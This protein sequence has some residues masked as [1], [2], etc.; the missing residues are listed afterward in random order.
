MYNWKGD[1]PSFI[2]EV[3]YGEM[4]SGGTKLQT[5]T[6]FDPATGRY[7]T[8]ILTP[9]GGEGQ[10]GAGEQQGQQGTL[11]GT[12][13]EGQPGGKPPVGT[14]SQSFRPD[15]SSL[16]G[17][18]STEMNQAAAKGYAEEQGRTYSKK[19]DAIQQ[20]G[21]DAQ[22]ELPQLKALSDVIRNPEFY[23]GAAAGHIEGASSLMRSMGLSSGETAGLMQ[24]AEKLGSSSSLAN[25]REMGASGA[26]RVPEMHMIEKMNYDRENIPE[27][28][29]AVVDVRTKLQQRNAE[30]SQ[31]AS[32][33]ASMNGGRIDSGFDRWVRDT[34]A[35]KPLLT[36]SEMKSYQELMKGKSPQQPV[37]GQNSGSLLPKGGGQPAVPSSGGRPQVNDPFG[38]RGG[39]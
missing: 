31:M 30:I 32:N 34:Y 10:P 22:S 28:N 9:G 4:T 14:G 25:V 13:W 11:S 19:F 17:I 38:L 2:P 39:G 15:Y 1:A 16:G 12:G 37:P 5:A 23:S 33:Y 6:R 18:A 21:L 27:A 3:R 24:L 36:D 29:W 8:E 35:N 7:H 20:K 26:V